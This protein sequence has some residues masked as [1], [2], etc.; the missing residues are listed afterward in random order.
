MLLTLE[1]ALISSGLN[2]GY[3][4]MNKWQTRYNEAVRTG[5]TDSTEEYGGRLEYANAMRGRTLAWVAGAHVYNLLDCYNYYYKRH[6]PSDNDERSPRGALLRSM[7]LPGWGQLYN[8]QYAKL[9]LLAMA[10]AGFTTNLAVWQR[11]AGYYLK[12][13]DSYRARAEVFTPRLDEINAQIADYDHSLQHISTRLSDTTLQTPARDSLTME[14]A[15]LDTMKSD[16]VGH[17]TALSNEGNAL[18]ARADYHQGK[19]K[20][21][22]ASRNENIWYLVALY[23][24]AAF[25]AYVDAHFSGFDK[26]LEMGLV[27]SAEG[28][29]MTATY[30]F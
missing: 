6:H 17:R 28:M 26:K 29:A 12:L 1:A 20:D 25:D 4:L 7:L 15:A 19:K 27:P 10:A 2:D 14:K 9:G 16:A 18:T 21:Y 30:R 5:N 13:E 3:Y 11:T 24:Y 8:R 23:F 22:Y